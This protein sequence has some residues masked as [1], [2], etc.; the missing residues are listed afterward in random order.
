MTTATIGFPARQRAVRLRLTRRGRVV[1]TLL[2]TTPL[3]I[4][5]LLTALNG[6]MA[7]ATSAPSGVEFSYI[8]VEAGQSLWQLAETVAPQADPRDVIADLVRFNGLQDSTIHP[9][10]RLAIPP[11]Y[12]P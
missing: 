8:T 4:L 12:A 10:E 7:T 9:G 3:V 1:L 11:A 6:G 2:A 5:A